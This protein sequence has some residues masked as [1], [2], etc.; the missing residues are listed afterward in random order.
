[1]SFAGK[2]Q[3]GVKVDGNYSNARSLCWRDTLFLGLGFTLLCSTQVFGQTI[4]SVDPKPLPPLA[5]PNDPST[6]AK[7]LFGRATEPADLSAR[8]IGFYSRGCLAGAKALP[9]NGETWQVMRISRNR[10]WGHPNLVRFLENLS[11]RAPTEAGWPGILVGDMSQPRGGPMITGHASHQIGL[12][13]DI[14]LTPMPDRQLTRREREEMS[15]TNMVRS[16]GLDVDRSVWT[17]GQLAI[18]RAAA[19]DP[20][21]ERIFVNAAIKK[22]LCRDAT[23]NR[24]WL[25]KV[26]PYYGHN[27]HFHVRIACPDGSEV[28]KEQDPV[29]PGDGC[30]ESLAFWFKPSILHPQPNPN[31][32]PRPAMTMSA[33]PPECRKVLIAD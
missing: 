20:V 28:C 31:A 25:N 7:E 5:N 22:A 29:P 30:D 23:G 26:R 21:V 3:T 4:G 8:A 19:L 12:D 27:Y 32:K 13:A 15:A 14:W 10:M 9:V 1:M 18:I 2:G 24:S 6:P 33:L 16:D 11:A 17:P